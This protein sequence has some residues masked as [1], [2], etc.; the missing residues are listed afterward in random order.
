MLALRGDACSICIPTKQPINR[1][2]RHRLAATL[3]AREKIRPP[4]LAACAEIGPEKTSR[5]G[6]DRICAGYPAF[7]T[8]DPQPIGNVVEPDQRGFPSP[9]SVPINHFKKKSVA[10]VFNWDGGE[11][12]LDL[13]LREVSNSARSRW[14]DDMH[15]VSFLTMNPNFDAFTHFRALVCTFSLARVRRVSSG[16]LGMAATALL[17][18]ALGA[19]GPVSAAAQ[20]LTTF[21]GSRQL[22]DSAQAEDLPRLFTPLPEALGKGM[23][24]SERVLSIESVYFDPQ[25]L[26]FSS[27]AFRIEDREFAAVLVESE[28]RATSEKFVY[29]VEGDDTFSTFTKMYNGIVLG[30]IRA[31]RNSYF[32][33]AAADHHLVVRSL[34]APV[35]E[36]VHS[37]SPSEMISANAQRVSR[38]RSV[39]SGPL[40]STVWINIAICYDYRDA[41]GGTDK[42]LARATHMIDRQNTAYRLSGFSGRM[43]IRE[44]YFV[45][46]R[47][48]IIPRGLYTWATSPSGPVVEARKRTKAAATIVL[49]QGAL[50]NEALRTPP[51]PINPDREVAIC[52]GFFADWDDGDILVML[53][54]NGHLSGGDHNPESSTHGPLDP[55]ITA[56]DWYSCEEAIRGALS[57][58]VCD[59]WLQTIEMYSGLAAVYGGKVRGNEAQNNVGT[60]EKVFE[61]MKGEHN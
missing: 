32:V 38:R 43:A 42:A 3:S 52:G 19:F 11:K 2:R 45:D 47:A 31:G 23:R 6:V 36:V 41:V 21:A 50:L 9:Q 39:R 54:E 25:V 15:S 33:S 18:V 49:S 14:P 44:I 51:S 22:S 28:R 48:E 26:G 27:V 4:S 29:R 46:P 53:H 7:E 58:N 56:R 16:T 30:H 35:E 60:F 37:P 5:V 55:Q 13:V 59:R 10:S 12:P 57:Y 61:F 8:V 24:T 17:T 1:G 20:P 40:P 34:P